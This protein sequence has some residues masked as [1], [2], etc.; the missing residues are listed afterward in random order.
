MKGLWNE[1]DHLWKGVI[2]CVRVLSND[3]KY[4]P[5]VAV[6]PDHRGYHPEAE[7]LLDESSVGM[8]Q[9]SASLQVPVKV[10]LST[11]NRFCWVMG[12][13]IIQELYPF[14]CSKE[15]GPVNVWISGIEAPARR[16]VE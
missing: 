10:D 15:Q 13:Q 16:C 2:G 14:L 7:G 3:R 11:I 12:Y 9:T 5:K 1:P 6:S 4:N 8:Q